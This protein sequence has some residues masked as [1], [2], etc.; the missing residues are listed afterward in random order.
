VP[1]HNAPKGQPTLKGPPA[2]GTRPTPG[3]RKM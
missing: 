1:D 2:P 3:A